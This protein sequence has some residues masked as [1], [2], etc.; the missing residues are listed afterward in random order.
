M[1]LALKSLEVILGG[2]DGPGTLGRGA[3]TAAPSLPQ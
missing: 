3:A 2:A 1:A